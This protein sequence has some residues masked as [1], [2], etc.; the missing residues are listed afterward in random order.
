MFLNSIQHAN[1]KLAQSLII[2]YHPLAVSMNNYLRLLGIDVLDPYTQDDM[3]RLGIRPFSTEIGYKLNLDSSEMNVVDYNDMVTYANVG[4]SKEFTPTSR[5]EFDLLSWRYYK[6]LMGEYHASDYKLLEKFHKEDYLAGYRKLMV[7]SKDT[8]EYIEL[9]KENLKRHNITR[10]ALSRM[11]DEYFE[12]VDKYPK[13]I[14]L[15]NGIIRP[16]VDAE[17]IIHSQSGTILNY[18]PDFVSQNELTILQHVSDRLLKWIDR[19]V[20]YDY[21]ITDRLYADSTF[22]SLYV[23]AL[24]AIANFRL[25]RIGTNEVSKEHKE[26]YYRGSL[27]VDKEAKFLTPYSDMWLYKNMEFLKHNIGKEDTLT[28][29]RHNIIDPSPL[30]L[31]EVVVHQVSPK[32]HNGTWDP[33]DKQYVYNNQELYLSKYEGDKSDIRSVPVKELQSMQL[34]EFNSP[35]KLSDDIVDVE[36]EEL[37]SPK[38]NIERTKTMV[39]SYKIYRDIEVVDM[40]KM[41]FD[42]LMKCFHSSSHVVSIDHELFGVRRD[43]S[44][45]DVINIIL[46]LMIKGTKKE[47]VI[48]KSYIANNLLRNEIDPVEI[49]DK[50]HV[51]DDFRDL[52]T[53]LVLS[54]PLLPNNPTIEVVSEYTRSAIVWLYKVNGLIS[55]LGYYESAKLTRFLQLCTLEE[56]I[57][58]SINLKEATSDILEYRNT[59]IDDDTFIAKLMSVVFFNT[60]SIGYK[61]ESLFKAYKS[62]VNKLTSYTTQI[63]GDDD[64]NIKQGPFKT[65][66]SIMGLNIPII[67]DGGMEC[68]EL[69]TGKHKAVINDELDILIN[70][71]RSDDKKATITNTDTTHLLSITNDRIF[72][73]GD[74]KHIRIEDE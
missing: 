48:I 66:D 25:S 56:E 42:I 20:V 39:L 11:D 57:S 5:E 47:N 27:G 45:G 44:I 1:I 19:W 65:L 29:I 59:D 50:L 3:S 10:K 8:N 54:K 18:N 64:S 35:F 55:T 62:L 43:L 24:F 15:I 13:F 73:I 51:Y 67:I 28:L 23:T 63:V 58:I 30:E 49:C 36:R 12:L 69:F 2:K 14:T 9:T 22:T 46:F 40:I 4:L 60:T 74:N 72:A 31:N 16:T 53:K 70:S 71:L 37:M 61:N 68:Y 21:F 7:L 6:H 52:I 32:K 38:S 33:Y 26:T 17:L 41:H 34:K